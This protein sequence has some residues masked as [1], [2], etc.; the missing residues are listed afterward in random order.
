MTIFGI[1]IFWLMMSS[2][3]FYIFCKLHIHEYKT[4]KI[5]CVDFTFFVIISLL[6]W[7]FSIP[8]LLFIYCVSVIY[9]KMKKSGFNCQVYV[10]LILMKL[11]KHKNG[12][13]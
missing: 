10:D 1:I 5:D 6:F 2:L 11:F 4:L 12:G 13:F 3:S 9:K 7:F 8:I